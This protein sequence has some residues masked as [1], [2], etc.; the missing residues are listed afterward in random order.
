M[1][2]MTIHASKGLQFPV[3]FV[4]GLGAALNR[5]DLAGTLLFGRAR[6]LGLRVVD[7]EKFLEYPSLAHLLVRDELEGHLVEEEMR[8]LYVAM[9]RAEDRLILTASPRVMPENDGSEVG[10]DNDAATAALRA[11]DAPINWILAALRRVGPDRV[12]WGSGGEDAGTERLPTSAAAGVFAWTSEVVGQGL[13]EGEASGGRA[14]NLRRAVAGLAPLPEGEPVN[15]G[16]AAREVL[17]RVEYLYPHLAASSVPAVTAASEL[18]RA[19]GDAADAHETRVGT[20]APPSPAESGAGADA[21]RRRGIATHRLLQHLE[22]PR[23]LRE[24]P[25][26]Q[27]A[28]LI[29]RRVLSAEDADLIEV[30]AVAWFLGTPLALRLASPGAILHRELAFIE[31]G[32]AGPA[33]SVE[34]GI[35]NAAED[36]VLVRGIVDLA[37][38][39][40][41]AIELVDYKTDR[42]A[43]EA[44]PRRAT[45]YAPQVSSYARAMAKVF[46]KPVT[47]CHLVFLSARRV[48]ASAEARALDAAGRAR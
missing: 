12:S 7:R 44:V 26:P 47:A 40:D 29:A 38:E 30:E 8:V 17:T 28:E 16:D 14:A 1:R 34:G 42:V 45:E 33:G 36:R 35:V 32:P 46:R 41:E 3:V 31:L 9:T 13:P 23:A 15:S 6:G 2:I 4:A 39:E 25:D 18:K 5:K 48:I 24:G 37:L 22:F 20:T 19:F 27:V 10:I 21:A 11:A 43:A